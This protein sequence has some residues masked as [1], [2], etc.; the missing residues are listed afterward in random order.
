[1]ILAA[2]VEAATGPISRHRLRRLAEERGLSSRTVQGLL[3]P[4]RSLASSLVIVQ[5]IAIA[6]ATSL[7]TTL[8]LRELGVVEHGLAIFVVAVAY[9][10]IGRALPQAIGTRQPERAAA[11]L[12]PIA[13][14]LSFV[15]RPLT[16]AVDTLV[17]LIGRILPGPVGDPPLA[18]EEE[19]LTVVLDE[20]DDG[21]IEPEERQMI[22]GVLHL[23]DTSAR[24]IMVPRVDIVAVERS[25]PLA[26]IVAAIT[27]AGHSRIPVYR[28]SIDQ[29]IGVL[30]AKDLLPYVVGG[31]ETVP[32]ADLVR[33]AHIVPE[34][35]RL[36][37]LLGE[38]RRAKVHIAIVVD[39][40]GGTA[41]LLTIEDILEEIVGEIHDEYDRDDPLFELIGDGELLADG[42]LL[43]EDV[44][45]A[46]GTELSDDD[47]DTVGGF[48]HKHLGRMPREGDHFAAQGIRVRV[49]AV[50]GH[51]VRRLHLTKTVSSAD[52]VSEP[53]NVAHLRRSEGERGV[54]A[55]PPDGEPPT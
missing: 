11:L 45:Q 27:G 48:V 16:L 44:E 38:L 41:G 35:K 54:R 53:D 31:T 10:L 55:T 5:A 37:E 23:E 34:S 20:T 2:T 3:D 29:I 50:D 52:P 26:D 18:T 42:R 46:L 40:Y 13:D 30:Y 33:P 39:E 51:R 21:V 12:V 47:Y 36:D 49:L 4:R 15:V 7:L 28:D 14:L 25:V 22:D 32:L 43:I 24:D 9:V 1:M 8:F 6:T 19:F 17:T